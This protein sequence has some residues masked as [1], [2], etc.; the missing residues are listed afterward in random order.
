MNKIEHPWYQRF[1][2]YPV[3]HSALCDQLAMAVALDKTIIKQ[4]SQQLVNMLSNVTA[5]LLIM[6][7]C[8]S[9]RRPWS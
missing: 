2:E 7:P 3:S 8:S 1:K 5:E 9:R 6:T 4:S